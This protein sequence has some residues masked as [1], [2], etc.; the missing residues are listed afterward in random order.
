MNKEFAAYLHSHWQRSLP[1]LAAL[2]KWGL[3]AAVM[4]LLAGGAGAAFAHAV[5]WATALRASAPWLIFLLPVAGLAIAGLYHLGRM[6]NDRGTNLI[7]EGARAEGRPPLRL[8]ALIFA[9][10]VLTHL[11]GGSSGREG[12]ALQIGGSLG[13]AVA[14][15]LHMGREG[16]TML[17]LC[18]MSGLFSALFGTPVTAMV[19]SL[20]VASVGIFQEAALL[21]CLLSAVIAAKCAGLLGVEAEAYTL[22]A[23]AAAGWRLIGCTALLGLGCAV[24]S[25]LFCSA[26]HKAHHLYE[27]FFPNPFLRA[28]AGGTLVLLLTL[29]AGSQTYNGAGGGVIEAALEGKAG[30]WMFLIKI[31]FTAATLGAG[32]KGGEIVPSFFVGATFGCVVGGWLGLGPG[33]AAALGMVAVFCG[34]TNCPLASILLGA[35]LFGGGYLPMFALACAVS[36]LMSGRYSLYASQKMPLSKLRL[37]FEKETEMAAVQE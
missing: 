37:A 21:P 31:L 20:E 24:V 3:L 16:H 34:V 22:A 35:E 26:M 30:G 19:F 17:L 28:A 7:L 33:F 12:A 15:R 18:G 5:S 36:D 32:F 1:Y 4:G 29:A 2:G 13:S 23:P 25:I 8:A 6:D 10:T 11:C 9:G 14:E 27:H